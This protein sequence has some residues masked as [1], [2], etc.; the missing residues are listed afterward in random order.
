[1]EMG[2]DNPWTGDKEKCLIAS[3]QAKLEEMYS[4]MVESVM[5]VRPNVSCLAHKE[6]QKLTISLSPDD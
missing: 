3:V 4:I 5:G 1:M 2:N 6:K